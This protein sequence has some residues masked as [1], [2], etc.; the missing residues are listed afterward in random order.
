MSSIVSIV[1]FF[2]AILGL[3][4]EMSSSVDGNR[5]GAAR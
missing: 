4:M 5:L 3:G 2:D 1:S